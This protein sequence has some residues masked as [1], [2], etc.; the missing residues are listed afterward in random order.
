MHI[1]WRQKK[2]FSVFLRFAQ[3]TSNKTC[4]TCKDNQ[5]IAFLDPVASTTLDIVTKVVTRVWLWTQYFQ[6]SHGLDGKFGQFEL[7]RSYM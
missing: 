2:S 6:R 4:K 5:L 7:P 1:C 3:I